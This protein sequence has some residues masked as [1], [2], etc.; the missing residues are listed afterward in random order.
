VQFVSSTVN[1][2]V[3]NHVVNHV[4]C[5]CCNKGYGNLLFTYFV[6]FMQSLQKLIASK[7]WQLT[8]IIYAIQVYDIKAIND[9]KFIAKALKLKLLTLQ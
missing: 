3:C 2:F 9:L 8:V 6:I 7:A 1:F 4:R 5:H